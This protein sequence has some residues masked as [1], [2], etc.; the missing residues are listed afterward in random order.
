MLGHGE[1]VECVEKRLANDRKEF[2]NFVEW[3]YV[4][5]NTGSLEGAAAAVECIIEKA[6]REAA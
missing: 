1:S 3:D 6:E 5:E 4:V 2:A